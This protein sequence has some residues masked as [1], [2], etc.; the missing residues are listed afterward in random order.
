MRLAAIQSSAICIWSGV[1]AQLFV[2]EK[3]SIRQNERYELGR[4]PIAGFH[5]LK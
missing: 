4:K 5:G 3:F 1:A 2:G